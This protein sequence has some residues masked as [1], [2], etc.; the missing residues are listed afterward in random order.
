M[1]KGKNDQRPNIV[2][3]ICLQM[4]GGCSHTVKTRLKRNLLTVTGPISSSLT[5]LIDLSMSNRRLKKI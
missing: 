5:I 3:S 1:S 2:V 4:F